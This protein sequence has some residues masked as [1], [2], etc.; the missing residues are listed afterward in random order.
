[1]AQ[2]GS[3]TQE[4]RHFGLGKCAMARLGATCFFMHTGNP[5][6]IRCAR[7][8]SV[9]GKYRRNGKKCMYLHADQ[10]LYT[11]KVM[12]EA[13]GA[14]APSIA[15]SSTDAP[16]DSALLEAGGAGGSVPRGHG[17]RLRRGLA[18]LLGQPHGV[19]PR[20]ARLAHRAR[21]A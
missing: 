17:G 8:V 4:C 3:T 12:T 13:A 14:G 1:M 2:L 7:G 6:E 10:S 16:A 9:D 19:G 18:R 11:A 20:P 21:A 5:A 15:G